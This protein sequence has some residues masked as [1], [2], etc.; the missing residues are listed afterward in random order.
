MGKPNRKYLLRKLTEECGEVVQAAMKVAI[1][2]ARKDLI[3]ALEGEVGD[4]LGIIKIMQQDGHLSPKAKASRD[5]RIV[6]ERE[7]A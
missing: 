7:K 6:R 2:G 4:V 3:D 5:A 1:H